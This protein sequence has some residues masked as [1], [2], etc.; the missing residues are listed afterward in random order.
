MYLMYNSERQSSSSN[1]ISNGRHWY[2]LA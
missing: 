2:I 1:I